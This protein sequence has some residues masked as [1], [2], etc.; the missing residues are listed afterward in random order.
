M[1]EFNSER[2][3]NKDLDLDKMKN[4]SI[5]EYTEDVIF[6]GKISRC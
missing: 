6:A 5:F 3:E 2:T 1:N 4:K